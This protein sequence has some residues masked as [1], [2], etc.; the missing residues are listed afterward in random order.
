[1]DDPIAHKGFWSWHGWTGT[2]PLWLSA[3]LLLLVVFL[4]V[5][6]VPQ[7]AVITTLA[8]LGGL[9]R[10][11]VFGD[12]GHVVMHAAASLTGSAAVVLGLFVLC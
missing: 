6:L 4:Q 5:P 3:A 9:V 10:Q 7:I 11:L 8:G 12:Y 2:G 1:M